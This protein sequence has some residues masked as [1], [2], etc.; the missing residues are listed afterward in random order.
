MV[1]RPS[2]H[3]K[4]KYP[5]ALLYQLFSTHYTA[6]RINDCLK[7]TSVI[8]VAAM[9]NADTQKKQL[10]AIEKS[11]LFTV[12]KD[13]CNIKEGTGKSMKNVLHLVW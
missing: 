10:H 7:S 8:K 13:E 4:L 12:S 5:I 11:M 3:P 2:Y 6:V 9:K 1:L